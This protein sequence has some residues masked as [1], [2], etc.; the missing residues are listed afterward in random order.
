[1]KIAGRLANIARNPIVTGL[2]SGALAAG[3]SAYTSMADE[4]YRNEGDQRIIAKA[5]AAGTLAGLGSTSMRYLMNKHAGPL[6]QQGMKLAEKHAPE[7]T[8]KV[9]QVYT[10]SPVI[11]NIPPVPLL[12]AIGV[13]TVASML[14]GLGAST[15]GDGVA[16]LANVA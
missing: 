8:S 5:I 7:L 16:D 10:S 9:K 15:I 1:M 4:D 12:E 11:N 14:G 13:S 2:G 6:A 3:L